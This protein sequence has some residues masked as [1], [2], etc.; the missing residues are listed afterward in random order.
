MAA[1]I[2]ISGDT[3]KRSCQ[4]HQPLALT[5]SETEQKG[6]HD[7]NNDQVDDRRRKMNR[8]RITPRA[9]TRR[10]LGIGLLAA[11]L[12][13]LGAT[14]PAVLAAITCPG[15]TCNGTNGNDTVKGTEVYDE[16][17]GFGGDDTIYGFAGNDALRGDEQ[18]DPGLDGADRIYGGRGN[19]LLSSHGG[20]D[21]LNAGRGNDT[22]NA[23]D[24]PG[25]PPGTDTI[26]AG[27][28]DDT[29]YAADKV[30]DMIDC[31]PGRDY[32]L[33]DQDLDTV[34]GCEDKNPAP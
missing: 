31:G 5:A 8:I 21:L 18:T 4:G 11:L 7:M 24:Y 14:A 25:H 27:K 15:F 1:L 30:K 23:Q 22:I 6:N 16:I 28:G 26:K 33:Y 19:D 2:S 32:V 10:A 9:F 20:A 29:I 13:A 17:Y 12:L 34:T 3:R